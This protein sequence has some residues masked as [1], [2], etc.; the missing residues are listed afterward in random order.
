M[1][2]SEDPAKSHPP[3]PEDPEPPLLQAEPAEPL[4]AD[5]DKAPAEPPAHL[6]FSGL[7]PA[8]GSTAASAAKADSLMK[9]AREAKLE[10]WHIVEEGAGGKL[11]VCVFLDGV[12]AELVSTVTTGNVVRDGPTSI[13]FQGL[14]RVRPDDL[15][16]LVD[17]RGSGIEIKSLRPLREQ[18]GTPDAAW[19]SPIRT[20]WELTCPLSVTLGSLHVRAVEWEARTGTCQQL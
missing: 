6:C 13:Y 8:A 5:G 11:E 15:R 16:R 7:T 18:P 17:A 1:C 2:C 4:G 10:P 9:L 14:L 19:T 12:E 20:E 3:T